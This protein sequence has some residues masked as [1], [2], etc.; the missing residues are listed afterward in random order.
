[1]SDLQYWEN[2][3][4]QKRKNTHFRDYIQE[5][6]SWFP[7]VLY[8]TETD[9]F[10]RYPP[11]ERRKNILTPKDFFEQEADFINRGIEYD[12]SQ[13]FFWNYEK[14]LEKVP[15]VSRVVTPDVENG[16]FSESVVAGK[17]IYLSFLVINGCENILYTFYA[18]D[19][20]KDTLNSVM[21]WDHSEIVYFSTSIIKSYKVFYSRYIVNSN[22]IWFSS[23]LIGCSECIFC[24]DL[25]NKKYY[26]KNKEYS[27]EE[28]LKKKQKI[29][30]QKFSFALWYSEVNTDGINRS[31]KNVKW[32]FCIESENIENGFF[33]YR[34]KNARNVYFVWDKEGRVNVLDTVCS[35]DPWFGDIYASINLWWVNNVYM[36]DC[37]VGQNLYYCFTCIDCS[38]CLGCVSLLNKSYCIFNKQYSKD[39]WGILANKI[40]K[41]MHDDGILWDFFPWSL[42]PFYF[43]DTLA[44]LIIQD[45]TKEEVEQ[46]WFLWRDD[47]I[48]VDI[49]EGVDI[50]SVNE[51]SGYQWYNKEGKWNIKQEILNKVIQDNNG[52]YYRIVPL[53]LSFLKKYWLPLPE[54]HWLERIK[55][56]FWVDK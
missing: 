13:N 37:C 8:K 35:D 19:N 46:E 15:V 2:K 51:L 23:N 17:N 31:S 24:D 1:M 28:Y 27:K 12:F 54:I 22:N 36:V 33:T 10:S 40:L 55:L 25:I 5:I 48:K 45:F 53:E 34:L 26:I 41:Q 11:T 39:E 52:D 43:N 20:V 4:K 56:N 7:V 3:I 42:N 14:L 29:L 18:Q 49:P 21:V 38:F 16:D 32:K 9:G 50:I 30:S 6:A 47:M 44:S